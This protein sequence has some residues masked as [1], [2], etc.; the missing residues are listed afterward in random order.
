MKAMIK[1][2]CTGPDGETFDPARVIGYGSSV[3]G[4][5]VFL[6]NSVWQVI[7]THTFDPQAYGVGFGAVCAG[8]MAVGIGVGAKAHT[9]PA[10]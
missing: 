10:A 4:V 2:M 8:I 5:G 9:E 3:F 1:M 7:H 6:F